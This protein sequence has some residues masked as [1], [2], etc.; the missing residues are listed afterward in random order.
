MEV[1]KPGRWF[2]QNTWHSSQPTSSPAS[3]PAN[4]TQTWHVSSVRRRQSEAAKRADL[5]GCDLCDERQR[6]EARAQEG[7]S[8]LGHLQRSQPVLHRAHP[9]QVWSS[10]V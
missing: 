8:I 10:A 4:E 6:S 2:R 1:S 7:V 9:A 3:C 5:L